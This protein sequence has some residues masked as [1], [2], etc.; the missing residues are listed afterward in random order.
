MSRSLESDIR[1]A[2]DLVLAEAIDRLELALV[3]VC[4]EPGP[5]HSAAEQAHARACLGVAEEFELLFEARVHS[6]HE[7]RH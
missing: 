2:T 5:A 4:P 7:T 1:S 3:P 6:S